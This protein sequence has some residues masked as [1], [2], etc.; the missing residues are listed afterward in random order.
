MVG[1]DCGW[2]ILSDEGSADDTIWIDFGKAFDKVSNGRLAQKFRTHEIY[3]KLAN[4][5]LKLTCLKE[6]G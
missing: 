5:I 1:T 6:G 4:W 2:E 3:G